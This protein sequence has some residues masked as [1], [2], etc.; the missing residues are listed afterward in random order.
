MEIK[1]LCELL[2]ERVGLCSFSLSEDEKTISFKLFSS[3]NEFDGTLQLAKRTN[4]GETSYFVLSSYLKN[5]NLYFIHPADITSYLESEVDEL[6]KTFN[7]SFEVYFQNYAKSFYPSFKV[8]N[9][10][11]TVF[12]NIT[13]LKHKDNAWYKW[14]YGGNRFETV[15]VSGFYVENTMLYCVSLYNGET[16]DCAC[17][18]TSFVCDLPVVLNDVLKTLKKF[19]FMK[20][21][22]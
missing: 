10:K 17:C 14:F 19:E 6:R 18:S 9:G 13:V 16:A 2:R 8:L 21:S 12:T 5:A 4:E 11:E 20:K 15:F 7:K 22:S 3:K 1:D